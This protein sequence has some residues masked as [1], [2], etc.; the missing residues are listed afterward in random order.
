VTT[1]SFTTRSSSPDEL[2]HGLL[3]GTVRMSALIERQ[4]GRVRRRIREALDR[5]VAEYQR[6]GG[7]ELPVSVKL[8]SG[9]KPAW[10]GRPW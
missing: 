9:R 2:W 3:G 5:R 7:L 8:A 10:A 4:P 1:I 6:P